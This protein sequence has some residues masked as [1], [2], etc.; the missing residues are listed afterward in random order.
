MMDTC[1]GAHKKH[2]N[3]QGKQ[4]A[5]WMQYKHGA[6]PNWLI[7]L[8]KTIFLCWI[9]W[10]N[11]GSRCNVWMHTQIV[12]DQT[13]RNIDLYIGESGWLQYSLLWQFSRIHHYSKT[14]SFNFLS[15]QVLT[16]RP[17]CENIPPIIIQMNSKS[18]MAA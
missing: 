12:M 16:E 9:S 2:G 3:T 5:R 1:V 7:S 10:S 8:L 4:Q 11:P 14:K 17:S 13:N 18:A 6:F 15:G